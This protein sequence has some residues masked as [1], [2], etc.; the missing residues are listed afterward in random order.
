MHFPGDKLGSATLRE[1]RG[2]PGTSDR[3]INPHRDGTFI[4]ETDFEGADF[5]TSTLALTDDRRLRDV[6]HLQRSFRKLI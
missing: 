1:L 3:S 4:D 5:N 6:T 2:Q